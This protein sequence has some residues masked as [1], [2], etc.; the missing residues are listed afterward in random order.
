MKF[1]STSIK[2]GKMYAYLDGEYQP[3]GEISEGELKVD[4]TEECEIKKRYLSS[5]PLELQATITP[6]VIDKLERRLLGQG[7]YNAKVLKRDG[8]LSPENGWVK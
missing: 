2:I 7:A 1:Y 8:Y 4:E 6:E 5:E 3:I